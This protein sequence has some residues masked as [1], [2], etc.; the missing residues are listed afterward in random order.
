MGP[1]TAIVITSPAAVREL[2]DKNSAITADRPPNHMADIITSGGK[3]MVLARY[4]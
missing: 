4:S 1:A 3:N 2:M